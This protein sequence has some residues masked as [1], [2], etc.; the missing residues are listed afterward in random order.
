MTRI[1]AHQIHY[2]TESNDH[3]HRFVHAVVKG[4]LLNYVDGSIYYPKSLFQNVASSKFQFPRRNLC[5]YHFHTDF[6]FDLLMK[7]RTPLRRSFSSQLIH[8]HRVN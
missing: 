1:S 6:I 7:C 8:I 5:I 3:Q 4:P 2:N